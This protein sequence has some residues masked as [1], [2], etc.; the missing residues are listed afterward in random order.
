MDTSLQ[1]TKKYALDCQLLQRVF[2]AGNGFTHNHK[3]VEILTDRNREELK[4]IRQTYSALYGQDIL[5]L[6]STT[7][8]SKH[9][10]R[11]AYLHMTEPPTRDAEIIRCCLSASKVDL[12]DLIEVVCTRTTSE[13]RPIRQAYRGRY[14]SE[15]EQDIARRTSGNLKEVLLAIL[16]SSRFDGGRVDMSM[17]MCDA[18]V[19][20]EAIESGR[21][22]D[23]KTI[24]SVI[25]QRNTRQLKAILLSYKQLYGPEFSRSLK[26]DKCGEFGKELRFLIRCIQYPDKYFAKQLRR[27]MA[28]GNSQEVIIRTVVTR[29]AADIKGISNAFA[30]KTG[31]S[32]ENLIRRVFNNA[33]K[34]SGSVADFLIALLKST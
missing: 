7:Q 25:G 26:R 16:N 9:F 4:L 24:I 12:D 29:A 19:L 11:A 30:A 10:A 8:K 6:L 2:S 14:N 15:I 32:L 5:Y 20:Y 1:L 34:A 22:I 3:L 28:N 17:A 18:K 13:L 33:D 21:T 27:A 31:W 23:K